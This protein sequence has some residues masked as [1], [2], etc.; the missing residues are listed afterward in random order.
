MHV[1]WALLSGAL[2][3]QRGALIP[4]LKSIGLSDQ[5]TRRAWA[6][7]GKGSWQISE[8]LSAWQ[9]QIEG[10]SEWSVQVHEGY[11]AVAV[12]V[13]AFWRPTL[14]NCPSKHFHPAAGRALPA[15]I[16]GLVAQVGELNGQ[17]LASPRAIERVHPKDTGE[18]RLWQTLLRLLKRHLGQDEV[19]VMDAGVKLRDVQ[20]AGLERFVRPSPT[21]FT[22]RRNVAAPYC[23][24]GRPPVYAKWA[25]PLSRQFKGKTIP[26]TPPDYSESWMQDDRLITAQVWE[27]LLLPGVLP[28]QGMQTFR[29]LAIH[30]PAYKTP[31]LLATPLSLQPIT[32]IAIY[33]DRWPVEQIPQS[34][35]Q[36]LVAHRQL[37]H[38]YH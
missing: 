38:A 23:G 11:R 9:G 8:L 21:N 14:K 36:M 3:P 12:D 17:R 24:Q 5:Q 15:V 6:A 27:N 22:A 4:A 31:W 29:V 20:E 7:F 35:K 37:V 10:F 28:H 13:T 33:A 1:V 2:L 30:D 32:L 18:A 25:P 26:S 34:V 19:A 16:M